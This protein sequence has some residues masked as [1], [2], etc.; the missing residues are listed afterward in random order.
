MKL[1]LYTILSILIIFQ[2]LFFSIFLI[3][4]QK[5][6]SI[7]NKIFSVFLLSKVLC[8][9]SGLFYHYRDMILSWSPHCFLFGFPF[10]FLLGPSL[11]FY[12]KSLCYKNFSFKKRDIIHLI[13]FFISAVYL[14]YVFH[15]Q[16][17]E[18]K[19]EILTTGS[20]FRSLHYWLMII[21]LYV[22][23]ISYNAAT[24]FILRK[25]REELKKLYSVFEKNVLI[26]LS[27]L[28]F[29]FMTIW[30]MGFINL[31]LHLFNFNVLNLY[32]FST[33]CI[34]IFSSM[35]AYKGWKQPEI[36]S[37]IDDN[38]YTNQKYEKTK[39]RLFKVKLY[40]VVFCIAFP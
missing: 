19:L 12:S 4:S 7:S 22:H 35:I 6:R 1:D 10:E 17:N 36:F 9:C 28:V 13:P 18:T 8:Y 23:F 32:M 2:F 40:E 27:L 24:L 3:N 33:V 37:G 14:I 38:N 20:L 25:Y 21:L 16:N 5:G 15:I 29:G 39:S 26:W 30:I 11:Y 31:I 34:F